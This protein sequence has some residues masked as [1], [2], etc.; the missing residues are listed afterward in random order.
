MKELAMRDLTGICL[1][2]KWCAEDEDGNGSTATYETGQNGIANT[3]QS[4]GFSFMGLLADMAQG[5]T[6]AMSDCANGAQVGAVGG[7]VVGSAVPAV[8]TTAGAGAG[9]ALGC[10]I[11]T[12]A[13]I[14]RDWGR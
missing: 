5:F 14:I 3:Q 8:G 7:A 13:G 1:G 10:T 6:T 2:D 9:A 4:D 11:N 12:G